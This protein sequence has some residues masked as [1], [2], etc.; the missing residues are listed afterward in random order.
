M[1][2]SQKPVLGL[3]VLV[4]IFFA[5][6]LSEI[7][8]ALS[9]VDE[10]V[11][12]LGFLII[13][14]KLLCNHGKIQLHI[15]EM[16]LA[17]CFGIILVLGLVGNVTSGIERTALDI[18]VE[19]LNALKFFGSYLLCRHLFS[20]EYRQN[21]KKSA[22]RF[23]KIYTVVASVCWGLSMFG[24]IGMHGDTRFGIPSYS[25]IYSNPGS[26]SN[27]CVGALMLTLFVGD[28]K[29]NVYSVLNLLLLLLTLRSKAFGVAV[30]FVFLAIGKK[31]NKLINLGKFSL[32]A[33]GAFVVGK[34]Q[35]N[36][37][38]GS[39][40][41]PRSLF[42]KNGIKIANDYFPFGAGLGTYGTSVAGRN[43]SPLYIKYGMDQYWFF[44]ISDSYNYMND[45]FWPA[46][47]VQY[48]WIGA[49]IYVVMLLSLYR[50][51][52]KSCKGDTKKQL[53]INLCFC[54]IAI[55]SL[56]GPILFGQ[57]GVMLF[58][59]IPILLS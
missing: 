44:Q 3:L 35:I 36:Y 33:I 1:T 58:M 43:Y 57:Y 20:K 7:I 51:L 45:N 6:P 2:P 42:L 4:A 22:V 40:I 11:S 53:A 21:L 12:I 19:T 46:I 34:E 50:N 32:A 52:I 49:A 25:F 14:Y 55:A 31:S 38:F 39:G 18:L 28:K 59:L 48:G 9:L 26:Y 24:N 54:T 13:F 37:Y 41:T 16:I 8:P 30:C 29:I 47:M 15:T 17:K 10:F 56:G 5:E 27:Y 23:A